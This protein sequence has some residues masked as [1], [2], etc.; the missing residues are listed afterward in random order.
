MLIFGRMGS[1]NPDRFNESLRDRADPVMPQAL[2]DIENPPDA[3]RVQP[4]FLGVR[5]GFGSAPKEPVT[6]QRQAPTRFSAGTAKHAIPRQV[7]EK[8]DLSFHGRLL[9]PESRLPDRLRARVGPVPTQAV[10]AHVSWTPDPKGARNTVAEP[11]RPIVGPRCWLGQKA[12]NAVARWQRRLSA[13]IKRTATREEHA[14]RWRS[15]SHGSRRDSMK[16]ERNRNV[17]NKL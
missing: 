17:S 9:R 1:P 11:N 13:T 8:R 7:D 16:P 12:A 14:I 15:R 5:A 3:I 6:G 2:R 4:H 10:S